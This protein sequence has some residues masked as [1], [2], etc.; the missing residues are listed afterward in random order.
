[1]MKRN[2]RRLI[3]SFTVAL[4]G[5]LVLAACAGT[6]PTAS[7]KSTIVVGVISDQT[8]VD[9]AFGAVYLDAAKLV[10][11]SV[12]TIN[13]HPVHFI[14]EDDASDPA[15]AVSVARGLISSNHATVLYGPPFTVTALA[16][17]KVADEQH[18]PFYTPGS[19]APQLTTPFQKY[20]FAPQFSS[21]AIAQGIA[22][23]VH[24]MNVTR[25]GLLEE[26]DSYG[27]NALSSATKYLAAYH[28][29]VGTVA[30]ISASATDA[31]SQILQ[32]KQANDQAILLGVT[33]GPMAATLQAEIQQSYFVPTTTFA[34]SYSALDTIAKSN[35]NIEFYPSTPLACD[36]GSSCTQRFLKVWNA[37]YPSAP[38][39]VWTAQ[40]YAAAQAFIAGLKHAKSYTPNGI[41]Q[42]L[43]T[44]PGYDSPVLP[45]PI[46]FSTESHRGEH[47]IEFY[48]ITGGKLSFF[49]DNV[50]HNQL[51]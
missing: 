44:M 31:T 50:K 45:Q 5:G 37:V 2:P 42:G 40:A 51:G 12:H 43:E 33:A 49:G 4:V 28:L 9:A 46:K 3:V 19:I 38:A 24:S 13:G 41:V 27:T 34:G 32:F 29:K 17:A 20:V 6:T 35:T 26:T 23:L 11:D 39:I 25:I 21:N 1:M 15:T 47:L 8:G 18:V 16:L 22:T 7:G 36:L 48:G 14:Y 10:F 30:T